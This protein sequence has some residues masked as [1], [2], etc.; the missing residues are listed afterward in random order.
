MEKRK[1]DF[2]ASYTNISKYI[3]SLYDG[4]I[5]NVYGRVR[6]LDHIAVV[7]DVKYQKIIPTV[8]ETEGTFVA[9]DTCSDFSNG[10]TT[11]VTGVT[12]TAVYLKKEESFCLNEMEQYYFGQYM[13]RGSD[14][15][16]LPFEEA[17]MQN[18]MN[19]IAKRLD[20]MYW[21]GDSSVSLTG[22]IAVAVA[23][24]AVSLTQS[25]IG[26][27]SVAFGI[28]TA[29]NNGII[30]TIDLMIDN[31]NA[32]VLDE[33]DLVL[34]VGR[35]VFDRYTRSIR[36]LNFYHASPDEIKNGVS[37]IFGKNNVKLVATAGL[38]GQNKALLGKGSWIFW[39][40]DM[41]PDEETIKGEYSM[42]Y[43][44]YLVRYKVKIATGIAFGSKAVVIN[45]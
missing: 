44:K 20:T 43:D 14:Q 31:L 34:F 13:K 26:T 35:D 30:N 27:P 10:A 45:L 18:K 3:D 40:T 5:P 24:S 32:S 15:E 7:P 12:L 42:Y 37:P 16:E 8:S 41:A 38:N 33:E 23:A 6:T 2:S 21:L 11:S 28:S 36:N 29:V 19:V 9:A 17:F 39:G 25:T 22:E 1:L 4:F